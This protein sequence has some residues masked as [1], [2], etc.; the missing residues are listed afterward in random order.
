[1]SR[2]KSLATTCFRIFLILSIGIF[3]SAHFICASDI[4]ETWNCKNGLAG[5]IDFQICSDKAQKDCISC[6]LARPIYEYKPE[7]SYLWTNLYFNS[8]KEGFY[9]CNISV[10]ET[11]YSY[12]Q[13][14]PSAPQIKEYS[15]CSVE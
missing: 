2:K 9:F 4:S 13:G 12:Y 14:D 5:C 8:P 15:D 7:T 1:M 6:G 3:F 11:G 10:T